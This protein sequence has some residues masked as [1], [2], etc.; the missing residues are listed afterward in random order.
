MDVGAVAMLESICLQGFWNF[1]SSV[2]NLV[3][4]QEGDAD[5][6]SDNALLMIRWWRYETK[7]ELMMS[8]MMTM[9]IRY[10]KSPTRDR[11]RVK[12]AEVNVH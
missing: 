9:V 6:I 8:L 4:E 1:C 11:E 5:G 10:C 7:S 2:K 12:T 3:G